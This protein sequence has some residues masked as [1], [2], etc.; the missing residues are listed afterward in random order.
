MIIIIIL[1]T[2][3]EQIDREITRLIKTSIVEKTG[4]KKN[5]QA[6]NIYFFVELSYDE[7]DDM[8]NPYNSCSDDDFVPTESISL[9]S[10]T[11]TWLR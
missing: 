9:T 1:C 11:D 10:D 5:K 7:G 6:N 3:N 4:N 8:F 2:P